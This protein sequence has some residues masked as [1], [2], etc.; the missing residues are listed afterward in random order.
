MKF[1]LSMLADGLEKPWQTPD[2]FKGSSE[3]LTL[4]VQAFPPTDPISQPR[5]THAGL[6]KAPRAR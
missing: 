3:E 1:F 2:V 6:E 5:L 4:R